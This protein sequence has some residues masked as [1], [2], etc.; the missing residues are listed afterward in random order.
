MLKRILLGLGDKAHSEA[1][2]HHAIDLAQRHAARIT[3]VTILDADRLNYVG[4]VPMG[5]GAAAEELREHRLTVAGEKISEVADYVE[6]CCRDAKVEFN[7]HREVG[8]PFA[9]LTDRARFQDLMLFG[10][11]GVF[12]YGLVT[13]QDEK[14]IDLLIRF[15]RAGVRPILAVNDKFRTLNRVLIAYSG[16]VESARTVKQ[17]IRM[18]P[19]PDAMIRVVTFDNNEEAGNQRLEE[20]D[21]YCRDYGVSVETKFVKGSPKG[22]IIEEADDFNADVIVMG[23]SAKSLL[24]RKI[25][26]ETALYCL[27]HADRPVFLNQ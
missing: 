5:G 18:Q 12:D 7:L 6:Q 26:G 19:Q 24:S 21:G 22:H 8:D 2:I 16:S 14:P 20:V 3:A 27:K 9:I 10:L 15:I 17:F 25:F 4:P 11:T 23:N 1:K 13:D